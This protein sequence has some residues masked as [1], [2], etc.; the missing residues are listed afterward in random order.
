MSLENIY[1]ISQIVS[2]L[3]LIVSLLFVGIQIRQNTLSTQTARHQSIV[4]AIADWSREV[5]LNNDIA[6]L[7]VRGSANFEQLD[8]VQRLQFALL[9]VALFRNYE[10]IFYQHAQGA[11][12]NH[13][14]EGWAYRMRATFALPGVRAW[15]PPQRDSYSDAFRD[16]LEANPLATT[17][18]PS[19]LATQGGSSSTDSP[20][21][22]SGP[23][24]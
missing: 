20:T 6:N 18:A 5:A 3:A 4:Q 1:F 9:H 2:A 19:H 16:F 13:V 23:E 15:W 8:P 10:N 7:M 21:G 11:I 22:S 17:N 12:D 24:A 14:W